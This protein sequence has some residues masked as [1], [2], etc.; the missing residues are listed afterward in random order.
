[1]NALYTLIPRTKNCSLCGGTMILSPVGIEEKFKYY[2][3]SSCSYAERAEV[4]K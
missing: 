2:F 3:C 4:H 1:M